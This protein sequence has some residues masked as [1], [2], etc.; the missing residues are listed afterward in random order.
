[1]IFCVRSEEFAKVNPYKKIPAMIM[2]NGEPLPESQVIMQVRAASNFEEKLVPKRV[3]KSNLTVFD[4]NLRFFQYLEDEYGHL[5]D[6]ILTPPPAASDKRALVNLLVR[7]H[8]IYISSP[9]NTQP[10]FCHTQGAM[11]KKSS[12]EIFLNTA[13]I[14]SNCSSKSQNLCD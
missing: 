9:N 6:L 7:M 8:D 13:S 12:N 3:W 5:G 11:L 1:M 4:Q 2:A 14:S 10:N